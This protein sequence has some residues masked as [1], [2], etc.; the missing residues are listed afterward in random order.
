MVLLSVLFAASAAY[1]EGG[2]VLFREDFNSLAGWGHVYF[3]GI[4]EHST[5]T[6]ES[7]GEGSYLKAQSNASASVLVYKE[8]FNVHEYPRVRWRWRIS[9][10]Y[11][12]GD[13]RTKS[14]DDYPIR[15]YI[16]FKY[17]PEDADFFEKLKYEAAKWT[18]GAY[19]PRS[20]L[21]YIWAN[22]E[23]EE[24]VLTN[25]YSEK[26]RLIVLQKGDKNAGRWQEEE[27]DI[28]EDY[29][30][31]FGSDP[32]PYASVAIMNDSDNT[33]EKSVSYMDYLEVYR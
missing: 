32:P 31:A 19:P 23:L 8:E 14:G 24:T 5:Y 22:K 11:K 9:N 33:K 28:V 12:K 4:K 18:Y 6:I 15:V 2:E 30:R 7:T 16:V 27:V 20:S 29:R 10:I 21:N 13:A 3:P 1:P 25:R 26:S 17:D